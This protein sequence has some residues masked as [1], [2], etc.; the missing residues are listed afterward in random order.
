MNHIVFDPQEDKKDVYIPTAAV[1]AQWMGNQGHPKTDHLVEPQTLNQAQVVPMTQIQ[2]HAGDLQTDYGTSQ[3][4][5]LPM[6]V[7]S[8]APAPGTPS[9][10]GSPTKFPVPLQEQSNLGNSPGV[11]RSRSRQSPMDPN[12]LANNF[13]AELQK[14]ATHEKP[15][16][17]ETIHSLT[18]RVRSFEL[19]DRISSALKQ[20]GPDKIRE[21]EEINKDIQTGDILI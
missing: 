10:I 11:G 4:Q 20:T 21:I 17:R 1:K 6:D 3:G 9:K 7:S 19:K 15:T 14:Y 12:T 13:R 18:S 5:V 16:Q 2:P 8:A